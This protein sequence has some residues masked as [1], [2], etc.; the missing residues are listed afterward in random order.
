MASSYERLIR[1][2]NILDGPGTIQ[3]RLANAY[4][5]ELQYVGPEGL[6]DYMVDVLETINDELTKVDAEGDKDAIDMS[7]DS[8]T[9]DDAKG[10]VDQIQDLY[11]F[12]AQHHI[13]ATSER[14]HKSLH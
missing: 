10:L 6:D 8:M 12:L 14:Y 13:G 11:H 5:S 2:M 4:R 1:A 7:A 3:Q 9:D